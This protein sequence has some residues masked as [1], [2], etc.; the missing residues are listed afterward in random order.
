[1]EAHRIKSLTLSQFLEEVPKYCPIAKRGLQVAQSK[2]PPGWHPTPAA[3]T[4]NK[5]QKPPKPQPAATASNTE[6][7]K[8]KVKKDAVKEA[9]QKVEDDISEKMQE[10]LQISATDPTIE[11]SKKLKRIRKKLREV[12]ELEEKIKNGEIKPEKDQLEK[13]ARK[14]DFE[15]VRKIKENQ[16]ESTIINPFL[17]QEIAELEKNREKIRKNKGT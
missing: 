13:V 10:K 4:V 17:S 6:K 16:R 15:A 12:D 8:I 5:T 7:I 11:L 9:P 2:Y 3:P 1:L 14:K